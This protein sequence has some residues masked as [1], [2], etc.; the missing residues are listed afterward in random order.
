MIQSLG[1]RLSLIFD[2]GTGD[3]DATGVSHPGA[4]VLHPLVDFVAYADDCALS[5]R[6]RLRAERLTDMLNDHDELQL[7]D[8]LVQSVTERESV[9]VR[10]VIV[11]RDELLLVHATGPRGDLTRR[12]RTRL[13]RVAM[14][15]DRYRVRGYLHAAPF[16][17]ALSALHRRSPMVPLT[18]AVIDYQI[19]D[20]WFRQR[21]GT[22]IVNR[23]AIDHII[24]TPDHDIA[25]VDDV[26]IELE[27]QATDLA[28]ILGAAATLPDPTRSS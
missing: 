12:T 26:A 10:E 4:A 9:E 13:T 22:L 23:G 20:E 5:G 27:P 19:G 11:P 18:D 25:V 16:I 21:V 14:S 28:A 8:V 3:P 24:E 7:V 2:R 6:I 17:D 1:R 15:V